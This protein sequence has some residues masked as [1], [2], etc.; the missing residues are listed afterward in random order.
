MIT[1]DIATSAS[2][3]GSRA[4]D[5]R[6]DVL[7]ELQRPTEVEVQHAAEPVPVLHEERLVEPV[8]RLTAADHLA[9]VG[10]RPCSRNEIG[11]PGAT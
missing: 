9:G 7:A 3:V 8:L 1:A 11:S 2:V 6:A 4:S 10:L 5:Q